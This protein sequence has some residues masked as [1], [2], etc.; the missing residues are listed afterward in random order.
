MNEKTP[1]QASLRVKPCDVQLL[2]KNPGN[3]EAYLRIFRACDSWLRRFGTGLSRDDRM[4]I[5]AQALCDHIDALKPNSKIPLTEVP[6]RLQQSLNRLRAR[7]RRDAVRCVV[8][9]VTDEVR[10]SID[11]YLETDLDEQLDARQAREQ[12]AQR[13]FNVLFLL[14]KYIRLAVE[15]LSP[16]DY[17]IL[18][19]LYKFHQFGLP[20][21]TEPVEAL[22]GSARKVAV[23]RARHRFLKDLE[24]LLEAAH[25]AL[26]DDRQQVEDALRLV[27][28]PELEGWLRQ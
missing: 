26:S 7:A 13:L 12:R 3:Q 20:A 27:R 6:V 4:D 19:R 24:N 11:R 2:R 15:M 5:V 28:S 17:A 9:Q 16:R 23:F 21:P 8:Y 14:G 25:Q 18:H 1:R 10:E 22:S